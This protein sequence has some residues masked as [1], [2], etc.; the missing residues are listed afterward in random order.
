MTS[1]LKGRIKNEKDSI[2]QPWQLLD[3]HTLVDSACVG[4]S[5]DSTAHHEPAKKNHHKNA[6]SEGKTE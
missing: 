5:E 6:D 3:I 2:F 1:D 4:N